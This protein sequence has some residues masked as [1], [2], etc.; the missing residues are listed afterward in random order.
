MKEVTRLT[1]K[2]I[3]AGLFLS[4]AGASNAGDYKYGSRQYASGYSKG[5]ALASAIH[6]LP[7][8]AKIEKVSFNGYS[9]RQFVPGVGYVQTQGNYKCRIDYS[10]Y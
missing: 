4:V 2:F 5:D 10:T 6:R 1:L 8:G 7:Y 9:T 3:A